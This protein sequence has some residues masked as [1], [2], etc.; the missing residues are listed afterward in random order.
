MRDGQ[1]ERDLR[2]CARDHE[3]VARPAYA[4]PQPNAQAAVRGGEKARAATKLDHD[5][6]SR[7]G[8]KNERDAEKALCCKLNACI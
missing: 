8:P 1:A 3:P 2:I 7:S 6:L 4:D 5:V